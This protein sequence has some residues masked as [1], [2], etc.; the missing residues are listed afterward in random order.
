MLGSCCCWGK[1]ALLVGASDCWGRVALP[2]EASDCWGRVALPLEAWDCW[3][4]VV[5]LL[6][7]SDCWGRVAL[8]LGAW[9]CWGRVALPQGWARVALPVFSS[10]YLL[11]AVAAIIPLGCFGGVLDSGC[12]CS[13]GMSWASV[14]EQGEL[15]CDGGYC[16]LVSLDFCCVSSSFLILSTAFLTPALCCSVVSRF[17]WWAFC[18]WFVLP[19]AGFWFVWH[20]WQIWADGVNSFILQSGFMQYTSGSGESSF[21][22]FPQRLQ[23]LESVSNS[24]SQCG[25]RFKA[26]LAAT[27]PPSEVSDIV[28]IRNSF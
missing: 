14:L 13:A 5:L 4:R 20:L 7:A 26:L 11:S 23:N 28:F 18:S 8:P 1:G 15:P 3:G 12:G 22:G 17:C 9:D 25:H 19:S 27:L 16:P 24:L 10:L 6:G 21:W 2:L